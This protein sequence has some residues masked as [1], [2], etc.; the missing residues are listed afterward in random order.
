MTLT[1]LD[2]LTGAAVD[3]WFIYKLPDTATDADNSKQAANTGGGLDYL[4]YDPAS[5][6]A[7]L[8]QS[9]KKLGGSGDALST[10]LG[11]LFPTGGTPDPALVWYAYNDEIPNATQN[12]EDKGHTKGVVAF[13]PASKTGFWLL[14]STPRYPV[15]GSDAFPADE[16]IYGQTFLCVTLGDYATVN[17]IAGLMRQNQTPQI[18]H[19][20]LPA[21]VATTDEL[22]QLCHG[23]APDNPGGTG[24]LD[25]T[26]KG[27][28]AFKCLAK[29]R[30]WGKDFWTD[31]VGPSLGVDLGIES[32]RRGA[33]PGAEDSTAGLDVADVSGIDLA[34]LGVDVAWHYTRDHAKWAVARQAG[35]APAS[36]WVCVAD[37][38]RQ[39]S[40]AKRGGGAICFREPRLWQ[41]LSSIDGLSTSSNLAGG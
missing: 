39:V 31:L 10:T 27:G 35:A 25:F 3:W 36:P 29:D 38:N 6:G 23:V 9:G 12:D 5:A 41:D 18:Y 17:A 1:A 37:I 16:V 15:V 7:G 8:R 34:P 40:Q 11:Q 21:V 20:N 4:Y 24:Q 30:Q 26:S 13:D 22:Y 14:H 2:D 33:I 28:K 32:W 19:F